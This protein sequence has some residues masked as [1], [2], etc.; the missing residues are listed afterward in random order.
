MVHSRQDAE[1]APH[2]EALFRDVASR[3]ET[4]EGQLADLQQQIEQARQQSN[5]LLQVQ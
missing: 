5:A 1:L 2:H 3:A 4:A